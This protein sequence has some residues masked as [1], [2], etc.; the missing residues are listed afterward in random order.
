M[1]GQNRK[2]R[3]IYGGSFN[4]LHLG[5]MRL[6][7]ECLEKMAA[8]ADSLEFLPTAAPP[9]KKASG[10]LPFSLRCE[11]V[12]TAITGMARFS[13]NEIEAL[14]AG[15]SYTFEILTTLLREKADRP[16][17]FIVGSQDFALLPTWKHGLRLPELCSLVVAKRGGHTQADF[18][19]LAR[20][21]WPGS[22]TGQG[23]IPDVCMWE[24]GIRLDLA[25]GGSLYWLPTP[26]LDISAS[27][28]RRLWLCGRGLEYLAPA[29]V[30]DILN[31]EKRAV[32]TC[33]EG[34]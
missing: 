33:W 21:F 16:L 19:A 30:I 25:I 17:F 3:L 28:L 8:F 7:L 9:H 31:R 14:C 2:G 11:M 26:M 5:H 12:K 15:P 18:L 6:A 4:P 22:I 1:P 24:D 32:R 10:L 23:V 34:E 29:P 27:R 13:C 20:Q